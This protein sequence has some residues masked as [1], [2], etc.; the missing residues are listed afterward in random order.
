MTDSITFLETYGGLKLAKTWQ[1]DGTI[2]SYDKAKNYKVTV[3]PIESIHDIARLVTKASTLPKYGVI[4]G[5]PKEGI[6]LAHSPK[7]GEHFDDL[8]HNWVMFDGDEWTPPEGVDPLSEKAISLWV[9]QFLPPEFD[10]INYFWQHSGS[11]GHPSKAGKLRVHV[12]FW[13]KTAYTSAQ[14]RAWAD[15]LDSPA[16]DISV[17]QAVQHHFIANPVFEEGQT[18]PVSQ[19]SGIATGWLEL[20]ESDFV[21]PEVTIMRQK[22]T[23]IK[24]GKFELVDPSKKKGLIGAF[25]RA[26]TV[27]EVLDTFLPGEFE[28]VTDTRLT[29]NLSGSGISEGAYVT[30]DRMHMGKSHGNSDPLKCKLANLWDLVRV[31]KF[32]HLDEGLDDFELFDVSSA[33]SNAAMIALVKADE[34]V[35]AEV[36]LDNQENLAIAVREAPDKLTSLKTQIDASIDIFGLE[37]L[38]KTIAVDRA[39]TDTMRVVLE[40]VVQDK[41]TSLNGGRKVPIAAVREWLAQPVSDGGFADI[42]ENGALVTIDNVVT[43]LTEIGATVRYNSMT[44]EDEIILPGHL[45]SVDNYSSASLGILFSECVRL[46]IPANTGLIK[47]YLTA[48]ADRNLY[49]P[50]STWITSKPWDGVSRLNAMWNTLKVADDK[51]EIRDMLMK[52]WFVS[53]VAHAVESDGIA[54]QGML[55]LAGDQ[56]LGKSRWVMSLAPKGFVREGFTLDTKDKDSIFQA[57]TTWITE[58]AE[59]DSTFSRQDISSIKAFSTK[60]WDVLRKPFAPTP[61]KFA[62]KTGFIGTVNDEEYL[63]DETG[64][65]RFWTIHV[66]HVD[67]NH[68]IDM[69]QLWAEIYEMYKAGEPYFLSEDELSRLNGHNLM[70]TAQDSVTQAITMTLNWESDREE[71]IWSTA[72]DIATRIGI[73]KPNRAELVKVARTVRNLNGKMGR[74]GSGH[75]KLLLVPK[76]S[77]GEEF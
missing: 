57:V 1:S 71:W 68:S 38:S 56:G 49:N 74:I 60:Q 62:R 13:N 27:E 3:K 17:F 24:N 14:W 31:H 41:A 59:I 23:S 8:P 40:G 5:T 42:G 19:R 69:Q 43:V 36:E 55:V 33:P 22:S 48:I 64:A 77:V 63:Y 75:V 16:F 47:N 9:E 45:F 20:D 4:R 29:W 35:M 11:A 2:S 67:H 26:Y 34:R 51:I 70:F 37:A 66:F 18:D 52:R 21:I 46:G 39:V 50:V 58:L 25:H 65:R 53:A 76:T 44:K 61:S 73:V 12:W 72:T 32:G 54:S 15:G 10:G 6:D 7:D 28:W 30:P